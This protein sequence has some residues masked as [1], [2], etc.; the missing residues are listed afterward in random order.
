MFPFEFHSSLFTAGKHEKGTAK[1]RAFLFA[2]V[3]GN[4][5]A[6]FKGALHFGAINPQQEP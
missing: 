6:P 2:T 4:E 1:R 3:S 5:K